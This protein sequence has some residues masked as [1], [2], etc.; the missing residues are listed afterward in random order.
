MSWLEVKADFTELPADT[1]PIIELF[2]EHGIENT[3]ESGSSISGCLTNVEGAGDQAQRL[4]DALREIGAEVSIGDFEEQNWD[5]VWRQY[6]QPRRIGKRLV[7]RPTWKEFASGP[8]DIEIVLDPGQAF[9][10]G[11]HP[12]T[13]LCLE[14]LETV[15]VA[16]LDVADVGCGSGI[17]AIGAVKLG[18]KT[19]IG[20][21]I[22]PVA[23]E[24]ANEN[25]ALN[26]VA[27][28]FVTAE[29]VH[30]VIAAH[31]LHTIPE[32]SE[33]QQDEHPLAERPPVVPSVSPR[34]PDFDLVVSN[35][36][37][38]ILIRIAADVATII[39]PGGKW[40][41]SGIIEQNW[42]DVQ[43]G[44]A[45][46]GFRLETVLQEDGWVAAVFNR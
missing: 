46:A 41:V 20:S 34:T 32:E 10:T 29:G 15:G 26:Q 36:I 43:E 40:I 3:Q 16:G 7:I 2:R 35:I 9:G 38:A 25:A 39:R 31:S 45:A 30:G 8:D 21:D 28:P 13:R 1:S 22:D 23:V 44:A 4:S 37:S 5:E 19:V 14:L 12:T 42:E 6:F 11:D 17:L 33:W 24:V 18:A 27:I